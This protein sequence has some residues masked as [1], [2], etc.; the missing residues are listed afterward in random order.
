MNKVIQF[1][2]KD[3]RVKTI[4]EELRKRIESLEE[5]YNELDYLHSALH[6]AEEKCYNMEQ[7]YNIILADYS[8]LVPAEEME[9]SFLSY[10]TDAIV[11]QGE[12]G[13]WTLRWGTDGLEWEVQEWGETDED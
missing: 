13:V 5:I 10:S 6:E 7:S 1:P 12:D 2:M 8:K 11:E 9:V 4:T 3:I